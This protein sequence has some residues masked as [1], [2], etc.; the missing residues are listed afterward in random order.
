[1]NGY[2]V[3]RILKFDKKYKDIPILMLTARTQEK[4]QEMGEE[5]GADLYV[6]KPFEMDRLVNS[7]N[8]V[9]NFP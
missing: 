2:Q 9:L 5:T 6:T 8:D 1:M 3:A 4:D 7:V